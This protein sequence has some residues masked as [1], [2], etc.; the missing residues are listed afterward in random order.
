MV[1]V[2]ALVATDGPTVFSF[3]FKILIKI[4]QVLRNILPIDW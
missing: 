3:W 1:S 4:N 2:K